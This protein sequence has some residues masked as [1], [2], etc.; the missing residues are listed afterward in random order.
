MAES[1]RKTDT[2]LHAALAPL[3]MPQGEAAALLVWPRLAQAWAELLVMHWSRIE[4][5]G[6]L[7]LSQPLYVLDLAPG[8]G[9]LAGWLL[10]AL[11]QQMHGHGMAGWPVRYV[12]CPLPGVPFDAG[13]LTQA[14][15]AAFAGRGRL[16]GASWQARTGHPL[17][18][19]EARFP[20]FGV[21]N[22]LAALCAGGLSLLPAQCWGMHRGRLLHGQAS[23]QTAP[24]AA[25]AIVWEWEAAA[26]GP[27]GAAELLV[28]H[29]RAALPGSPVLLSEASLALVDAL[30]DFSA[31]RYLLLAADTGVAQE[32][33][34]RA[35]AF[36]LPREARAGE[37]QL[38]V[39][40]HALG[41]HQES[42]GAR[43]ANLEAA[44]SNCIVHLAW[45]DD[46]VPPCDESWQALAE[47]AGRAH[48]AQRWSA[49]AGMEAGDAQAWAA[50]L[51]GC[52]Q[53]PWLLPAVL[54]EDGLRHAELLAR[55]APTTLPAVRESLSRA[56]RAVP[57]GERGGELRASLAAL[58]LQLGH[59]GLARELLE[60]PGTH[61]AFDLLRTRLALATGAM[62][63][64]LEHLHRHLSAHPADTPAQQLHARLQR[65][66]QARGATRWA[67]ACT[68]AERDGLRLEPL[69]EFHIEPWLH[70]LRDTQ[71]AA[72]AGVA[73]VTTPDECAAELATIDGETSA[74]FAL[75]DRELGFIGGM[76]LHCIGDA[77]HLWFWLG[78]EHQGQRFGSRALALLCG[79]LREQRVM[80]AFASV[81]RGNLR[82]HHLLLRAGFAP[83]E[84]GARGA[85]AHYD[86]M[87]LALQ[88]SPARDTATLLPR[89]RELC[90]AIGEPLDSDIPQESE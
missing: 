59:Y 24:D 80:H 12:L 51:Q 61:P 1:A 30:A 16:H 78:S 15:L 64:A 44:D 81:H 63:A 67:R 2:S 88:D 40:F 7:D 65:R 68:G 6:G 52:A 71:L 28:E 45:R 56:W 85:D 26:A 82:S 70:H 39:N 20:L 89:L 79:M 54:R 47:H 3:L 17:L 22:P 72:I 33:A 77:V 23:V 8:D 75:V 74:E 48:P 4:R 73:P 38:P 31:S 90:A 25:Q 76:G 13:V 5:L 58:S 32:A 46:R 83:L 36:A 29:Y 11:E 42:A 84:C 37:L 35:G 53:D 60:E 9:R 27:G 41:L 19:G 66:W 50:R 18:L 14:P 34:I 43:V 87:H 69:D 86:F 10:P 49:L 62:P 57:Q 21:R 55:C